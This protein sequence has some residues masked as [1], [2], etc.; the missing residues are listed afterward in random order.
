MN[1]REQSLLAVWLLTS[2]G[3][4]TSARAQ[5]ERFVA[6]DWRG[7]AGALYAGWDDFTRATGDNAPDR[8]GSAAGFV[9][10][11]NE[12]TAF[13]TSSGNLY[14]F[15]APLVVRIETPALAAAPGGVV[16]QARVLATAV[17]PA[18]LRLERES[19]PGVWTLLP[20]PV[21]ERL[22]AGETGSPGFGVAVDETW[23]W[24]WSWPA[25][26][27]ATRLRVGFAA[28]ASSQSLAAVA[29]DLAPPAAV[30]DAY[31]VWSE[32]RFSAVEQP[33]AS[34]SGPEADPDGDGLPN[35]L[36]YALGGDPRSV[37]SAPRPGLV[38]GEPGAPLALTFARTADAALVYR[39]EASADLATWQTVF[40][41][42]GADNSA[43]AAVATDVVAPGPEQPRRFLRLNVERFP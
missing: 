7:A 12:T 23:R 13:V 6:P 20:A 35:L 5:S 21:G 37:L 4:A 26:A 9:L 22:Q 25:G 11:Q 30:K 15:A 40:V 3:V 1:L 43:G 34:I 36:E 41:S 16:L 28:S 32:A 31:V 8:P 14:S 2:V 39:V 19:E 38:V 27:V 10:R 29:L 33:D 18:S 42:T 24:T 17:D